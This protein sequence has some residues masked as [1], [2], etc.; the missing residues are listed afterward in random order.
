M[1]RS[2]RWLIFFL[3]LLLALGTLLLILGIKTSPYALPFS[4]SM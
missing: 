1:S 4:S 2:L 3:L